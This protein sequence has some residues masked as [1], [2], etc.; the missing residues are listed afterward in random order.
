MRGPPALSKQNHLFSR[1]RLLPF[2]SS[3]EMCNDVVHSSTAPGGICRTE[4]V[5]QLIG[6]S[7]WP[8][9]RLHAAG[10][11]Q[12]TTTPSCLHLEP[13]SSIRHHLPAVAV[14]AAGDSGTF[15]AAG[16]PYFDS[17]RSNNKLSNYHG[18]S[19]ALEHEAPGTA[20]E[21]R[22]DCVGACFLS[23]RQADE[24]PPP[25]VSDTVLPGTGSGGSGGAGSS[26]VR[27]YCYESPILLP[28]V[29]TT[30]CAI[31]RC[32]HK[33]LTATISIN[34]DDDDTLFS[35][36]DMKGHLFAAIISIRSGPSRCG[37]FAPQHAVMRI[38]RATADLFE[39]FAR[40][41]PR[42]GCGESPS[43]LCP[44]T[45]SPWSSLSWS[46]SRAMMGNKRTE[47]RHDDSRR[48]APSLD[49]VS[50]SSRGATSSPTVR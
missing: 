8:L 38:F 30:A 33:S 12:D 7:Q 31:G 6:Q 24:A 39:L 42:Q 17:K 32:I 1:R 13:S 48:C 49:R 28:L 19:L 44:W 14:T 43:S 40:H 47:V 37:P 27:H 5:N 20:D 41:S 35:L 46:S 50:T 36:G 9:V 25:S 18:G 34:E 15:A 2:A 29:A 26:E 21:G 23:E 16:E 4:G 10:Q 45:S 11:F 22:Y 3:L